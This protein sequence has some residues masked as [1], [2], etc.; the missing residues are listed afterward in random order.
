MSPKPLEFEALTMDIYTNSFVGTFSQ[1]LI[2]ARSYWLAKIPRN[3][4]KI[5]A[6]SLNPIS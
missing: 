2:L 5:S 1:N 4:S 6:T 3:I